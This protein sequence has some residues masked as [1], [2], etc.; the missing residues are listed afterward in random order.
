MMKIRF[1]SCYWNV[2]NLWENWNYRFERCNLAVKEDL[3]EFAT[4]YPYTLSLLSF[5]S[6]SS[7]F[8]LTRQEILRKT[9]SL[10]STLQV[11]NHHRFTLPA[12]PAWFC[13]KPKQIASFSKDNCSSHIHNCSPTPCGSV[14]VY[15][16]RAIFLF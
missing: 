7:I 12:G 6:S 13:F 8:Q 1:R 5:S 15:G 11:D 4:R 3:L 9:T 2:W 16:T 14:I 10:L